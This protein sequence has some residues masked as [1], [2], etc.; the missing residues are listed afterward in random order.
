[1]LR[2]YNTATRKVEDFKPINE[3]KVGIYVCGLTV[4]N[5]MH[6]GHARTYIAFDVIRRWFEHLGYEVNFVQNHTDIDD[7]IIN[8]AN[9][10]EISSKDLANK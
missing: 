7:K 6:L 8:R 2:L 1:M 5:D 3:N 4:Y 10:E 9:E